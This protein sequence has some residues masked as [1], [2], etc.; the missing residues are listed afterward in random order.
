MKSFVIHHLE[1][2]L[3]LM[4]FDYN[5]KGFIYNCNKKS[6]K[7]ITIVN[8]EMIFS[9]IKHSFDKKYKK[10]LEYY[11]NAISG[12]DD[13]TE[14]NIITA[15]N[16]I[17]RLKTIIFK[18][19]HLFLQKEQEEYFLKKLKILENELRAKLIDFKLIKEQELVNTNK[20]EEK[21]AKSR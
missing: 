11:L 6:V 21:I 10:M 13:T 8:P 1:N 16:E 15:L 14:G 2:N 4:I 7:E 18:K 9:L 20:E 19:Y 12:D 5:I 17:V 3:E